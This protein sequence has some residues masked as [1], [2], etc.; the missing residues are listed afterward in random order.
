MMVVVLGIVDGIVDL[1]DGD[2]PVWLILVILIVIHD[3][4]DAIKLGQLFTFLH[5]SHWI[6]VTMM[7]MM[8]T[9]TTATRLRNERQEKG[10]LPGPG[11]RSGQESTTGRRVLF[12]VVANNHDLTQV[13]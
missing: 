7:M 3:E 11:S 2:G 6:T 8:M 10:A 4:A 5:W 13:S 12:V 9:T 1:G